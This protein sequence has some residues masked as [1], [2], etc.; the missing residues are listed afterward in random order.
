MATPKSTVDA[1]P[2][3]P[4]EQRPERAVDGA[5]RHGAPVDDRDEAVAL[6]DLP[7]D[8][9]CDPLD[10]LEVHGP[11]AARGRTD[12]HEHDVRL[13][14]RVRELRRDAETGRRARRC[15]ELVEPRL[16]HRAPPRSSSSTLARSM[17][18]PTTEWPSSARQAA[19]TAPTYP[20]PMTAT[21][22]ALPKSR[23]T[24]DSQDETLSAR[25]NRSRRSWSRIPSRQPE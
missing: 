12:A 18:T 24:Y 16:D 6:P 4:L 10:V 14:Q 9:D 25:V 1:A 7:R 19:V 22:I 13:G 2:A 15:D 11:V 17:S 3:L 21:S 5:G 23:R 20:S 8:L